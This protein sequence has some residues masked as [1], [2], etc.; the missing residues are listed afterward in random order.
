MSKFLFS[1]F[2]IFIAIAAFSQNPI[3]PPGVYIAD[4]SAHVFNDGKVYIY[5]SWDVSPD[6]YC[7]TSYHIASSSNLKTWE[8]YDEGFA[9]TGPNDQVSYNDGS[10]LAPDAQYVD[11]KYYLYYCQFAFGGG[12]AEGI[13]VADNPEGPFLNGTPLNVGGI[14]QID[15]SVFIDDDGQAYYIWGQFSAKMAKMMP[16]MMEID[17]TSIIENV[18]TEEKHFFHEGSFMAKRNGIYYLVYADMSRGGAPTSI[19]YSYS[20]SPMGPYTYGGVIVDNKFCDPAV[21]NNHGSILEFKDQWYV[22]YHR[23]THGSASMRKACIEP[24]TFREDGSIPE[25]L[26]TSQGAG[27]PLNAF[28]EIDAARACMLTG[29]IRIQTSAIDNEVLAET[30]N[31]DQAVFRYLDFKDGVDH[32]SIRVAPGT[33]PSR[34]SIGT[35]SQETIGTVEVPAKKNNEE[36]ITLKIAVTPVKGVHALWLGFSDPSINRGYGVPSNEEDYEEEIELCKV[37]YLQFQ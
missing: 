1:A 27:D 11:G 3:V 26:M 19:G 37:D 7:S 9:T 12:S 6:H 36:W 4:P 23:S 35:G 29:N 31:G 25:V 20:T 17:T 16:N 21:W 8:I 18:A 2:S 30:F 13:A 15:P 34:I 24:I 28:E 5:G 10:L 14:E 22:F 33:K 32:L